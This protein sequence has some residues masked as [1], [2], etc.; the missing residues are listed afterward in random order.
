MRKAAWKRVAALLAALGVVVGGAFA[1][2]FV[3]P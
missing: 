3:W 2:D 1:G